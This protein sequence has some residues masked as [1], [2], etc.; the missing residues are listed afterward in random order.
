[1]T[2]PSRGIYVALVGAVVRFGSF[3]AVHPADL[4][5]EAG[6]FFPILGPSGCSKITIL[7]LLSGFIEPSGG[8]VRIGGRPM[9]GIGPSDRSDLPEPCLVSADAGLGERGLR[10]R[11]GGLEPSPPSRPRLRVP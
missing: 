6:A 10:A 7:R 1:M 3:Q 8:E 2:S 5:I 4:A 9:A 11:D